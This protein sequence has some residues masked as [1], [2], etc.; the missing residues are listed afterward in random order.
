MWFDAEL[1][2]ILMSAVLAGVAFYVVGLRMI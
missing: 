2:G 1:I